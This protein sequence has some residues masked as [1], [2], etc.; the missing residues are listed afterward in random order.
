MPVKKFSDPSSTLSTRNRLHAH[1][2]SLSPF[3]LD[4]TISYFYREKQVRSKPKCGFV[5]E[6]TQLWTSS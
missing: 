1:V 3:F 4:I 6:G 5:T 2:K